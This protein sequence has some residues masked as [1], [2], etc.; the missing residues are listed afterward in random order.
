MTNPVNIP[1]SAFNVERV[2]AQMLEGVR[3]PSGLL[4]Q[5]IDKVHSKLDA[6]TT[7]FFP[8]QGQVVDKVDVEDHATQLAAV[9]KI[10]SMAG[11]YARE[12]D[13]APA[14]PQVALEMDP[15]TGVVRLVVGVGMAMTPS[16]HAAHDTRLPA[17]LPPVVQEGHTTLS[18]MSASVAKPGQQEEE[19]PQ[20]VHVRKGNL[21]PAVF[22]ALFGEL[23]E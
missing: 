8:F 4:Q 11:V 23:H 20:V 5:A 12:R 10:L 19:I 9:E 17:E 6:K 7:K 16:L 18:A 14:V 1:S 22:D 21:P 3:I 2:R 15:R 13:A